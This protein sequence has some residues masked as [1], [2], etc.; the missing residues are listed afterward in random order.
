MLIGKIVCYSINWTN[1]DDM[2]VYR[3]FGPDR[4]SA[5]G[6]VGVLLRSIA[7]FSVYSPHTGSTKYSG[8]VPKI[9]AAA[10]T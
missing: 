10:I 8:D 3:S 4:A 2:R 1:Y 6:A 5:Y 9:P 7:S